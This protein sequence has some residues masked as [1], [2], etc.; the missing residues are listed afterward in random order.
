MRLS[1]LIPGFMTAAVT[2]AGFL[3]N[4]SDLGDVT[5]SSL[6]LG[7]AATYSA[8]RVDGG[9]QKFVVVFVYIA[10]AALLSVLASLIDKSMGLADQIELLKTGLTIPAAMFA[11]GICEV[12]ARNWRAE[13]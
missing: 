1:T 4:G 7:A 5:V 13:A 11:W 3:A 8:S 2:A 6:I 10:T 12:I 9:I